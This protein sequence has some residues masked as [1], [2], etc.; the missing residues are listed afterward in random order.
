MSRFRFQFPCATNRLTT[1]RVASLWQYAHLFFIMSF[2]LS[3]ASLSRMVLATDCANA[4]LEDLTEFYQRRSMES[5]S[6]GLRLYYSVGL[7]IALLST[8]VISFSHTH[9]FPP[10]CRLSKPV[11]LG[12]R[13]AVAAIMCALSAAESL[14]SLSHIAITVSLMVWVLLLEIWGTS[15]SDDTFFGEKKACCYTARCTKKQLDSAM[16]SEGEVDVNILSRN[17]KRGTAMM[18]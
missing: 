18:D 4:P 15:C 14:S 5:V 16:N 10:G 17:E 7:G 12:N 9:K 13:L 2:I 11:R 8:L 6:L 3:S 1:V